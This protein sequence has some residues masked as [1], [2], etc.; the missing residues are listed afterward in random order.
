[1]VT[2]L[3]SKPLKHFVLKICVSLT[4]YLRLT[5]ALQLV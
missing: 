3:V 2:F 5:K 1:L 4:H